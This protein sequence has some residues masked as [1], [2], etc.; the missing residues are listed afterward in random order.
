[1]YVIKVNGGHL[2]PI[3]SICGLKQGGV[4][5][6]LLFNLFID[7]IK[8]IFDESCDPIKVLGDHISHLLY[9]D[10][11]ILFSSTQSGLQ[12]CLTKLE[13][14][15]GKNHMEVNI[16]KARSSFSIYLG[17]CFVALNSFINNRHLK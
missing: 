13:K 15:C 17:K 14:Y 11:L 16:K 2:E 4:L 12:E 3:S 1:M 10:D 7:D 5:S 9:A 6:P 8:W